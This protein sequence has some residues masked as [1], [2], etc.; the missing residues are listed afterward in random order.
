MAQLVIV[1]DPDT[2]HGSQMLLCA[3]LLGPLQIVWLIPTE[4][5]TADLDALRD[6]GAVAIPFSISNEPDNAKEF[7]SVS[8]SIQ[9]LMRRQIPVYVAAG[10]RSRNALADAGIPVDSNFTIDGVKT[11]ARVGTSGRA[12]L[13]AAQ[14]ALANAN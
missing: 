11:P 3:T 12:V 13:A 14:A 4:S 9:G 10:N 8:G 5:L 1:D 6:V 2:E 7:D